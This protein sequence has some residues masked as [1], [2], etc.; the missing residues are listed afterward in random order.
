MW[1]CRLVSKF[2]VLKDSWWSRCGPL[3]V[4]EDPNVFDKHQLYEVDTDSGDMR[5]N[6][7]LFYASNIGDKLSWLHGSEL[8]FTGS[9]PYAQDVV[10]ETDVGFYH[11]ARV[12][13]PTLTPGV[14]YYATVTAFDHVFHHTTA[15]SNGVMFD[16]TPPVTGSIS[17][18]T[19]LKPSDI[20]SE[21]ITIHW[22]GVRDNESGISKTRLGV[23][24]SKDQVD[25]IDYQ[26]GSGEFTSLSDLETLHDGHRY[27]VILLVTNGAGLSSVTASDEFVVDRSAPVEGI[28][29]DGLLEVDVDFQP[30][31]THTGCL[32]SGFS[33]PP[34][35]YKVLLGGTGDRPSPG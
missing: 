25:V 4:T 6:K 9:N 19:Y 12:Q 34:L 31:T 30:N 2:F 22:T 15:V 16:N 26:N 7:E 27:Y 17:V 14:T 21:E 1:R 24:S 13:N 5:H 28:V 11:S 33:D 3:I 29:R 32:W 20:V 23:G 18:G 35:G 8:D 10:P